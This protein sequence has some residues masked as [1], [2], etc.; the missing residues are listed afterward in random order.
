MLKVWGA[1]DGHP[2]SRE[3]TVEVG[4]EGVENRV[5]LEGGDMGWQKLL[6]TS[7]HEIMRV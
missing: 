4:L 7:R 3:A 5:Q 6:K 2:V 1:H